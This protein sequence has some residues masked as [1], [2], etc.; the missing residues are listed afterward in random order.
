MAKEKAG[1][2]VEG[3]GLDISKA[4]EEGMIGFRCPLHKG[5]GPVLKGLVW[6][7]RE[8]EIVADIRST[9]VLE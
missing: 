3:L 1:E 6:Q 4:S 2:T 8:G 5:G 7:E 9:E